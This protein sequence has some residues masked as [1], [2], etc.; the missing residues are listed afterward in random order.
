VAGAPPG[1]DG[2]VECSGIPAAGIP[3]AGVLVAAPAPPGVAESAVD[4]GVGGA[5]GTGA[6]LSSS[7][8]HPTVTNAN[9][10][11]AASKS[12]LHMAISFQE[13]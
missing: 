4:F 5:V 7:L 2:V 11:N 3:A 1:I 8:L 6:V 13:V 9:A 10:R 12:F